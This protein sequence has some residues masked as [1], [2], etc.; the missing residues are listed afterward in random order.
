MQALPV[1]PAL[2]KCPAWVKVTAL[3]SELSGALNITPFLSPAVIKL[4]FEDS[5]TSPIHFPE[6][7]S[8]MHS[9][10]GGGCGRG[11]PKK[12]SSE[13][14][15][16]L[17]QP[18]TVTNRKSELAILSIFEIWHPPIP[19]LAFKKSL[20]NKKEYICLTSKHSCW[21]NYTHMHPQAYT[22]RS[23]TGSHLIDNHPCNSFPSFR[24]SNRSMQLL[25]QWKCFSSCSIW[26]FGR[27]I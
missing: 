3:L 17:S 26:L 9:I 24:D 19:L 25:R 16:F 8:H 22:H 21:H 6:S 15:S 2:M 5:W 4:R 1:I 7:K 23:V 18:T 10:G 14:W 12:H 11:D 27:L 13:Y 20:E